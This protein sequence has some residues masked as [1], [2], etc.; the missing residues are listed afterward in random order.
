VNPEEKPVKKAV[1][2]ILP[3]RNIRMCKLRFGR[4]TINVGNNK[5][6]VI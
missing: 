2:L 4:A 1:C 5:Y 3:D 6:K